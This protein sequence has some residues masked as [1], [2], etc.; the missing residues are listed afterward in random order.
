MIYSQS[1]PS[2]RWHLCMVINE[3]SILTSVQDTRL[4]LG[5]LVRAMTRKFTLITIAF[6]I[7]TFF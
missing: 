1:M 7:F 3:V 2:T 5:S 6:L 4:A